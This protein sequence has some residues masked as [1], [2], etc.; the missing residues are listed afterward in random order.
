MELGFILKKILSVFIMPLPIAIIIFVLSL[1]FLFKNKYLKAKIFLIL[2][3]VWLLL[4]SYAPFANMLLYPLENSYKKLTS[5]PSNVKY[6]V[7]LGGDQ[8]NRGWEVLRLNHKIKDSTIITSGYEDRGKIPEAIKTANILKNI[9]I[10]EQKIIVHSKP[11]DTYEEAIKIK[12]VLKDKKFIL[13]TSAYHMPR[14][15]MIFKSVHLNPIAAPTNFLIKNKDK[16]LSFPNSYHLHKSKK[17]WH[18]YIGLIWFN[19]SK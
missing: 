12:Q 6:I 11:K 10:N 1:Y 7:Y 4:F 17:A 3:L 15:M 14:A 5:I 13:V 18:E 16:V 2:A 9:G 19:L 8:Q